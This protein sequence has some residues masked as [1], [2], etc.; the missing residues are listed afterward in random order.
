MIV[1]RLNAVI[2]DRFGI[3][4]CVFD[5]HLIR[6]Q[7]RTHFNGCRKKSTEIYTL[8]YTQKREKK[9]RRRRSIR[10]KPH[11]TAAGS[12]RTAKVFFICFIVAVVVDAFS[13]VE[14]HLKMVKFDSNLYG[15]CARAIPCHVSLFIK[16]EIA[17]RD[18]MAAVQKPSHTQNYNK[19]NTHRS[20]I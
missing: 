6:S 10:I 9:Y 5:Y 2:C 20:K 4:E 3:F 7:H 17:P 1:R 15:A 11:E 16:N 13:F 19:I 14:F 12:Q 8:L 18:A